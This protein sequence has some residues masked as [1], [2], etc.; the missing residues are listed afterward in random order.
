[1]LAVGGRA[2]SSISSKIS[3]VGTLEAILEAALGGGP[4]EHAL[5]GGQDRD[6][7]LAERQHLGQQIAKLARAPAAL[8]PEHGAQDDLERH[9]LKSCVQRERCIGRPRLHLLLGLLGHH[10]AQAFRRPRR[11]TRAA[12][13]AAATV[14]ACSSRR[15]TEF[16]PTTG[17]RILAP[18]PGCTASGGAVNSSLTS[19]GSERTTNGGWKGSCTVTRLP[20]P[21][22]PR[23]VAVGGRPVPAAA[24]RRARGG[25]GGSCLL[26]SRFTLSP[27]SGDVPHT[28]SPPRVWRVNR[29]QR[30]RFCG[31]A[32]CRV[33][34][35]GRGLAGAR[36]A[37]VAP[38]QR[39][40]GAP[41]LRGVPLRARCASS[42]RLRSRPPV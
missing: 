29:S 6:R 5:E 4:G 20:V 32:G 17:S 21:P 35:A 14:R 3:L 19:A 23:S 36:Y 22:H 25:P 12:S 37:G 13:T 41:A 15:I 24:S 10:T 27:W 30:R 33:A 31:A 1:M 18:S 42:A 39:G 7:A 16:R 38:A 2:R 11:G 26:S 40:G 8:E 28:S 34:V 9:L